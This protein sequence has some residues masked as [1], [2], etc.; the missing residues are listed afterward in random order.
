MLLLRSFVFSQPTFVI[1][2]ADLLLE[3]SFHKLA[4][5]L[6]CLREIYNIKVILLSNDPGFYEAV[7]ERG[8]PVTVV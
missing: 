8:E 1:D 5:L 7:R 2:D 6:Q 4:N 3:G